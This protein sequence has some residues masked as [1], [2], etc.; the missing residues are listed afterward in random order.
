MD[1]L[2]VKLHESADF[3][4]K[5]IGEEKVEIAMVLGSGLGDLGE[6]IEDAVYIDYHDIPE[7][8]QS[9]E[10]MKK[11]QEELQKYIDL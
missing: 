11:L 2:M 5:K 6:K 7:G 3:I 9:R 10:E 8:L 1:E 4:N